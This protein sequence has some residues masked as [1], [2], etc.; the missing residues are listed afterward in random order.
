MRNLNFKRILTFIII[1]ALNISMIAILFGYINKESNIN[2]SNMIEASNF[3]G[4][5]F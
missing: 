3:K 2:P 1:I 5:N 4:M